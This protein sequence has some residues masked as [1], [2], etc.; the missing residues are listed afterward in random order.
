MDHHIS[1]QVLGEDKLSF[2][3]FNDKN[4]ACPITGCLP[5]HAVTANGMRDM[6][7]FMVEVS[8]LAAS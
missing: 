5:L 4:Q 7:N 1:L 2:L 3:D 6:Y 8:L